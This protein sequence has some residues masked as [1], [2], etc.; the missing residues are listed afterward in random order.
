MRSILF[1]LLPFVFMTFS[2]AQQPSPDYDKVEV[3]AGYSMGIELGAELEWIEHGFNTS[4]VYNFHRLVGVKVDVSGTYKTFNDSPFFKTKHSLYN[5][6]G[7][8]QIQ[9]NRKSRRVKPFAHFLVGVGIHSDNSEG[10]CPPGSF[11]PPFVSDSVGLSFI[12]GGGLDIKVNHRIDIRAVQF[13]LNPVFIG[14]GVYG[15]AR[16]STGVVFKF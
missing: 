15:N 13:D 10:S 8:I 14:D 4:A 16:F 3:F 6:T 9:N 7:G 11:C 5:V 12:L 1:V 2:F